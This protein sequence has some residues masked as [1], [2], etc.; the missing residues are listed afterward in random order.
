MKPSESDVLEMI[1]PRLGGTT[2]GASAT[3]FG[4]SAPTV[5]EVA[6]GR[7]HRRVPHDLPDRRAV[8]QAEKKRLEE[9]KQ[10]R[11]EKEL[12]A[13]AKRLNWAVL[14][15]DV[16]RHSLRAA[17]GHHRVGV[18]DLLRELA[19][20]KIA[21]RPAGKRSQSAEQFV[22]GTPARPGAKR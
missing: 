15:Y 14:D 19:R 11:E 17:A 4:M 3:R 8:V 7:F 16:M 2:L 9:R 20:G 21:R 13:W 5:A 1:Q 12:R 10:R 6:L 22:D 18:K